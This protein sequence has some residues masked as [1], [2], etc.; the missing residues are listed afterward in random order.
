[1]S[2]SVDPRQ[3][4][5]ARDYLRLARDL[6]AH[7]DWIAAEGKPAGQ[8]R[9]IHNRLMDVALSGRAVSGSGSSGDGL[10]ESSTE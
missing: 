7:P 2:L 9:R 1:M 8:R 5:V 4:Q 6:V 10:H 3:G